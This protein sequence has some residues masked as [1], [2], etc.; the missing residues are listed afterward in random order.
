M[1][2]GLG[3]VYKRQLWGVDFD[4]LAPGQHAAYRTFNRVD[5]GQR[6]RFLDLLLDRDPS[7]R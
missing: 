5:P 2:R 1:S 7:G 6:S 3:D 4:G